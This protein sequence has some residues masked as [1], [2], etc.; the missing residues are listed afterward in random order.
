MCQMLATVTQEFAK[1]IDKY[2]SF[3]NQD[4]PVASADALFKTFT[5]LKMKYKQL[6]R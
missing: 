2:T 5:G 3:N 1:D 6:V 4:D